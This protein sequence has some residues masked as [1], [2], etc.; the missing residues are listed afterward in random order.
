MFDAMKASQKF[1][2]A[3]VHLM[4]AAKDQYI[5]REVLE[6]FWR[7]LPK[8]AQASKVVVL[9]TE[10]KIPEAQPVFTAAWVN[11]ILTKQVGLHDGRS[12]IADPFTGHIEN[13]GN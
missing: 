9:K 11:S 2:K 7:Q 8:S 3:S 1:P 5:G 6:R 12:F 10:H 4:I 13:D